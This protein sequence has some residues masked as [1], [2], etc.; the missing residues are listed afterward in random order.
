MRPQSA[1][2]I[3]AIVAS[4]GLAALTPAM[5]QDVKEARD[6]RSHRMLEFHAGTDGRFQFAQFT[7]APKAAERTERPDLLDRMEGRLKLDEARLAAMSTVFPEFKA[8]YSSLTDQQKA[9]LVPFHQGGE[10]HPGKRHSGL[11]G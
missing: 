2:A 10:R 8:F 6:M 4:I 9:D 7:C 1:A 11:D 3:A 5:A